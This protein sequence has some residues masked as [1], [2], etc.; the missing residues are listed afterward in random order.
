VVSNILP[1][2]VLRIGILGLNQ[3]VVEEGLLANNREITFKE[4]RR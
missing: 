4:L 3:K 1:D 2:G